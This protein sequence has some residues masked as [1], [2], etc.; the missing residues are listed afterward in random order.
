MFLPARL[1]PPPLPH[2]VRLHPPCM[3]ILFAIENA[4]HGRRELVVD[5][6]PIVIGRSPEVDIT[7]DDRWASR[8]HCEIDLRDGLLIARDLGSKH[9]TLVNDVCVSEAVLQP[10][11]RL[12]VGLSVIIPQAAPSMP[13]TLGVNSAC[14]SVAAA[15]T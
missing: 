1:I 2:F 15:A 13:E 4:S 14:Q 8:R 10:G 5:H 12:C 3:H 9:G 6:F 7:L 11:D